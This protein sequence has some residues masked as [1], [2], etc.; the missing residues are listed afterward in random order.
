[1]E[2]DARVTATAPAGT[3]VAQHPTHVVG[4]IAAKGAR[5]E[6][7]G[8]APAVTVHQW[9]H[10]NTFLND[11]D[12][13]VAP[14]GLVAVNN[15]WGFITGWN[16][17]DGKSRWAWYGN[18]LFGAYSSTSA[19]IDQLTRNR[20]VLFILAAGNDGNDNGPPTAPFA[21]VHP[22]DTD[23]EATWCISSDGSGTDCPATP[24]GGRCEKTAHPADGQWSNVNRV[25]TSKNSIAVGAITE[26]REPAAFSSR[27]PARDGRVKPDL[28]AKGVNQYSTLPPNAYGRQQGTSMATP[29][30]TGIAALVVEQWRKTMGGDPGAAAL[31][32]LLIHGAQDLGLPGPDYTYGFGLVD[33]KASVDT[34]IADGGRG[35][36]I[37][38]GTIASGQGIDFLLDVPPGVSARVTLAWMDLE[39]RPFPANEI[40]LVNDLDLRVI[41][42]G[43]SSF[44]PFVLHP[45]VYET[46][47][48]IGANRR[49]SV[50]QIEFTPSVSG[51]WRA[52]VRAAAVPGGGAQEFV[53]VSSVPIQ[54][55]RPSCA[56]P[57]EPN[58]YPD[59]PWGRLRSGK[60]I[61]TRL[62]GATDVDYY[63]FAPDA[64][65]TVTVT[66]AAAG[67]ALRATLIAPNGAQSFTGVPAG[68]S[69][70]LTS[71]YDATPGGARYLLKIEADASLATEAAYM[72]TTSFPSAAGSRR[73]T[74]RR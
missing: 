1:V 35:T 40:T 55:S 10:E 74:A 4:T 66:V 12:P 44:A 60:S 22:N 58:D 38:R 31:K 23:G 19:G 20:N 9:T 17:D 62:C 7:K 15:S 30:V 51:S 18:D 27:G 11:I 24:C 72:V 56:D 32:A 3:S 13:K 49:D 48:S 6:A 67:P 68:G 16:Y 70:V 2:F 39:T 50:E 33:A 71:A 64:S 42:P 36:R 45:E 34:V 41:G 69:A 65:G 21:H 53:L 28:V 73:R 43:P 26:S 5:P 25:A 54:S 29:V 52:T 47:A 57:Y 61:S 59:E 14:L 63:W 8:M 37:A 46:E